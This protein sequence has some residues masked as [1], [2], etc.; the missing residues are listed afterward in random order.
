MDGWQKKCHNQT[1][2]SSQ[3]PKKKGGV[4]TSLGCGD[5]EAATKL[6]E[7]SV[8]KMPWEGGGVATFHSTM[9]SFVFNI[10]T[11]YN[12]PSILC[13]NNLQL[14]IVKCHTIWMKYCILNEKF[15]FYFYKVCIIWVK[16]IH[17][18]QEPQLPKKLGPFSPMKPCL[19]E[20]TMVLLRTSTHFVGD[21]MNLGCP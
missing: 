13:N 15:Y 2:S 3:L 11:L 17:L 8:Q 10:C 18:P 9:A 4:A 14:F 19:F 12:F 7:E 1:T 20:E 21:I 16:N 6:L 5:L